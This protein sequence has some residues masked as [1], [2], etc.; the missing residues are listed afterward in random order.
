MKKSVQIIL[1]IFLAM[2]CLVCWASEKVFPLEILR[3]N[4][5]VAEIKVLR[6]DTEKKRALGL[7]FRK[8][9]PENTGMFFV[10]DE[11]VRD[12]FWM[13]NTFISL[14]IIFIDS[15]NRIV[16]IEKKTKPL[17]EDLITCITSYRYVLEM[18]TGFVKKNKITYGDIVSCK[19]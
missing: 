2:S 4:K 13:K 12:P 18:P 1:V 19:E 9:L 6:A 10:F 7:M 11:N 3:D 5:V 14:D 17:S 16:C 15:S 8:D